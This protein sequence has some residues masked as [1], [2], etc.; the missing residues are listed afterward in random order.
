MTEE[1]TLWKPGMAE[2]DSSVQV[3]AQEFLN[4]AFSGPET[5]VSATTHGMFI[6]IL[7]GEIGYPNGKFD[8]KTAQS[9]PLLIRADKVSGNPQRAAVEPPRAASKCGKC[10]AT[11]K[12]LNKSKTVVLN[13]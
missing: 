4:T 9:I 12:I 1:D 5:I 13:G 8:M 3:R 6:R 11:P 10:E 7:L 2:T